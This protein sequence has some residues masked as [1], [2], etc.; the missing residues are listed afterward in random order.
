MAFAG[1]VRIGTLFYELRARSTKLRTDLEKAEPLVAK[2]SKNIQRRLKQGLVTFAVLGAGVVGASVRAA[3]NVE[4]IMARVSTLIDPTQDSLEALRK[5]FLKLLARKPIE[6]INDLGEALFQLISKGVPAARAIEE[7]AVAVDVS[8]GGVTTVTAAVEILTTAI[9]AFTNST[10]TSTQAGDVFFASNRL[11]A[12]TIAEMSA[13]L[14]Q[15]APLA[16]ALDISIEDLLAPMVALTLGGFSTA[17][18]FRGLNQVMISLLKPT[19]ELK[20]DFPELAEAFDRDR[21]EADG[22]TKVLVALAPV[23][24]QNK[25][26]ATALF[27]GAEALGPVLSLTGDNGERLARILEDLSDVEGETARATAKMEKRASALF[28]VF[29]NQLLVAMI[30]LGERILPNIIEKLKG[31][32]VAFQTFFDVV[33]LSSPFERLELQI[34]QSGRGLRQQIRFLSAE[35][36]DLQNELDLLIED[37]NRFSRQA[38]DFIINVLS[39]GAVSADEANQVLRERIVALDQ[40]ISTLEETIGAAG[41]A[42]DRLTRKTGPV[43]LPELVVTAP[44]GPSQAEIAAR[45]AAV[46]QLRQLELQALAV[47][48]AASEDAIAIQKVTLLK[49]REDLQAAVASLPKDLRA[50]AQKAVD[51]I[52]D[53]GRRALQELERAAKQ[54]A[55]FAVLAK[56]VE[57][58]VVPRIQE[59]LR[60]AGAG[61][62]LAVDIPGLTRELS[63]VIDVLQEQLAGAAGNEELEADIRRLLEQQIK[64]RL[65]LL[66]LITD[67]G[68][69]GQD[70]ERILADQNR[71]LRDQA[72]LIRDSVNGALELLTAFGVMDDTVAETVQRLTTLATSLPELVASIKALGKGGTFTAV[73]SAGLP[74]VGAFAGLAESFLG[75]GPSP[76]ELAQ[77][78][79]LKDNTRALEKLTQEIQGFMVL[80]DIR[81]IDILNVQQVFEGAAQQLE[82]ILSAGSR[83]RRRVQIGE[84]LQEELAKVGLSMDDLGAILEDLGITIDLVNPTVQ[85][86]NDAMDA[87]ALIEVPGFGTSFEDQMLQMQTALD[88]FDVTDPVKQLEALAKVA[89]GQAPVFKAL[90]AGLD[91]ADP[92][93]RAKAEQLIREL[94]QRLD[95]RQVTREELG[96]LTTNEFLDLLRQLDAG[97]DTLAEAEDPGTGGINRISQITL[98]QGDRIGDLL[99]Q[100]TLQ[101]DRLILEAVT[102]TDLLQQM[103]LAATGGIVLGASAL[104]QPPPLPGPLLPSPA[105]KQVTLLAD[106][107]IVVS[108]EKGATAEEQGAAAGTA[109][110]EAMLEQFGQELEV[111]K[112]SVGMNRVN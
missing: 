110:V 54:R 66:G 105:P 44:A 86:F 2:F 90:F 1:N 39:L 16:N 34:A 13:S 83:T 9:N 46:D 4:D 48:A 15:A 67:A 51:T 31:A 97:L 43:L 82:T 42:L 41:R 95:D 53:A 10:L 84:L 6:D 72:R 76:E 24:E 45:Q 80:G 55:P 99:L 103:A 111:R 11:G 94:F 8:I 89:Q 77:A 7:L 96:M 98:A 101:L 12:T 22:F 92:A 60:L 27:Q 25:K 68:A 5:G 52:V 30:E 106:L 85:D 63:G 112:V 18:A 73:V 32:T 71:K 17:R 40:E 47:L 58:N 50:D 61:F 20:K 88:I 78:Q 69:G 91:L 26:A 75:G 107:T 21:L 23:L 38:A 74:A 64:L 70:Q 104:G 81:N 37:N 3:S 49:L 33:G 109:A 36:D 19:G 93:D 14:S 59:A 35:R 102:Q 56:Q 62:E 87:L 57:E 108:G 28:Q 29:K 100:E 79:R 65:R